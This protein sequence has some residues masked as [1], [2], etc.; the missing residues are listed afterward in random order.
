VRIVLLSGGL[1]STAL[2]H[3]TLETCGRSTVQAVVFSYAHPA[4]DAEVYAAQLIAKRADV[5]CTT[6]HL[7]DL[8]RSSQLSSPPIRGLYDLFYTR[9]VVEFG[10]RIESYS[11]IFFGFTKT[12]SDFACIAAGDVQCP[13][14]L[15]SLADIV[16]LCVH[17]NVMGDIMYTSSC[18]YGRRCG[19]CYKCVARQDA[20][21]VAGV[22]DNGLPP[23]PPHG[24]DPHRDAALRS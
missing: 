17:Q 20:F 21:T 14:R 2:L 4:R 15:D 11:R 5:P 7:I 12:Q 23:P 9:T 13:F 10:H 22:H 19:Q 16:R 3:H 6:I 24:G 8:P 18:V 1:R